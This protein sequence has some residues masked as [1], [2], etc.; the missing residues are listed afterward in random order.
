MEKKGAILIENVMFIILNLI[1][2]SILILFLWK[3]GAGAV[4]LEQTHAKQISLLIDSAQS[5]MKIKLNMEKAFDL[6]E[7]NNLDFS[8]I[9]KITGNVVYVKLSQKGGYEYSFFKDV[10]VEAYPETDAQNEYTGNYI[11]TIN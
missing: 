9:V 5:D 3:Q 4:L 1:F 2:L 8:E 10:D 11:F 6:A 7:K